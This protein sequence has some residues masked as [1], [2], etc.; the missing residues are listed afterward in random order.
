[1]AITV[2]IYLTHQDLALSHTIQAVPSASISVV[3]DAG[4]DPDHDS[5]F[6]EITASDFSTVESALTADH[7]VRSFTPI[8]QNGE[9]RTYRIEY[10]SRAK[11]I[12]PLMTEI[13]AVVVRS[14]SHLEGWCL[15][16]RMQ[17][18]SGLYDLDEFAQQEDLEFDILELRQSDG[19]PE[20]PEVELTDAQREALVAAYVHGY[21]DESQE[22]VLA[23]LAELL[24]ISQSAVSGRL[25][26]GA[27][28][29]ID[30]VLIDNADDVE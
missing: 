4:T 11:L 22:T 28:Q 21:Y 26:R 10:S 8:I 20:H 14:E 17:D 29:L 12:S 18:H 2:E 6:F 7:T 19:G 5:Y 1:M 15:E 25:K 16:L 13:G 27:A 3:S 9:C 30:E 24:D 23:D